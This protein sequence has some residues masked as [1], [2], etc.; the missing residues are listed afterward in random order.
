M[1]YTPCLEVILKELN[2]SIPSF[3]IYVR[4][5]GFRI[6]IQN[7]GR[8]RSIIISLELG[9]KSLKLAP[10]SLEFAPESLEYAQKSFDFFLRNL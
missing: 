8:G 1:K 5:H 6:R 4:I 3:R 10:E 9:P 2:L 7:S